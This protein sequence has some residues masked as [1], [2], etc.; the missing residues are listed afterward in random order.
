MSDVFQRPARRSWLRRNLRW[1]RVIAVALVLIGAY[2]ERN[3]IPGWGWL[4]ILA[5]LF[6]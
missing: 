5:F 2:L 1:N 4:V 3:G 6:Y